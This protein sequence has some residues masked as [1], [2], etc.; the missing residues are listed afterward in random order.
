MTYNPIVGAA[1]CV[2]VVRVL[3]CNALRGECGA[4]EVEMEL[5]S[6]TARKGNVSQNDENYILFK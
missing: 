1:A 4:K 3:C 2:V 6:G 5:H